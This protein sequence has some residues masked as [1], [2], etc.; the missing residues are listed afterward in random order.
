MCHITPVSVEQKVLL[1]LFQAKLFVSISTHLILIEPSRFITP[2]YGM[3]N[4]H[5]FKKG[6]DSNAILH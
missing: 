4:R 3:M 1:G 2:N 6:E 5:N